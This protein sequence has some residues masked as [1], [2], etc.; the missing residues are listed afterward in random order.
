MLV[1]PKDEEG[2]E[3][4]EMVVST[5]SWLTDRYFPD[6]VVSG[7]DRLIV[8]DYDWNRIEA[9]LRKRVSACTGGDWHE[10]ASKIGRFARWEF[11]DYEP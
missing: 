11:Q 10:V 3:A 5:P 2:E 4:F 8:F 6:E 9:Y 1:G 7:S